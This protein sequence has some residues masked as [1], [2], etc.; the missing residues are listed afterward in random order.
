MIAEVNTRKSTGTSGRGALN[1]AQR[2]TKLAEEI[3]EDAVVAMSQ[4]T[5]GGRLIDEHQFYATR[6][7]Q[8][9]T[10][11]RAARELVVHAGRAAG[12]DGREGLDTDQA[13]LFAAELVHEVRGDVELYPEMFQLE[14]G[15]RDRLDNAEVRS[16]VRAGQDE[17]L[18][19]SIG[20]RVLE[21]RGVN[22]TDLD[23]SMVT[24]LRSTARTFAKAEIAPVAQTL[25][26]KSSLIP[27]ALIE[28]MAAIGFFGPSIDE[29]YGGSAMGYMAMVVL[30]EEL[31]AVSLA[32][33]SLLTR[34]EI[35]VRAL[36]QGGTPEQ[37]QHWLPRIASGE[38]MVGVGITEPDV[39][40]D[41][42]KVECKAEPAVVEGRKGYRITG[43]KSWSTFA[44][45]A[46]ILLELLRTHPDKDLGAQGLSVFIVE[47][48]RFFGT[49]FEPPPQ[50]GGGTIWGKADPTPGYRGMHS[51]S[52]V[53]KDYFVPEE[54]LIGAESG[55][56]KG[57]PL[58]MGG[59][60]AG[61]LQTGGRGTGVAQAGLEKACNYASQRRQFGRTI[62]DYQLTQY[63]LGRMAT[64]VA[65][66]RHLTYAAARTMRPDDRAALLPAMCK[67]LAADV[68]VRVTQEAQLIHGGWGYSDEDPMARYV[69]DALVLPLFEGVKPILEL[70][71][72]ARYLVGGQPEFFELE[73]E[74]EGE[75]GGVAAFIR[76]AGAVIKS[77][78]TSPR[79][80]T[81]IDKQTGKILKQRQG[82]PR[83]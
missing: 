45:R 6:R 17:R 59:L 75:P 83:R 28:K 63:K 61:R 21:T 79:S 23:D 10:K 50:P 60:A 20:A 8:L 49:K 26:S 66:A 55:L 38:V 51:F 80:T 25:H 4:L 35:L 67:L 56:N 41:I 57:F 34:S 46:D 5:T 15:R 27:D 74:A 7:A 14:E 39:G 18:A 31:S 72:I 44:G 78:I 42:A 62:A 13:F 82:E 73:P 77:S 70:K 12:K 24:E 11:A 81:T 40:S 19:R 32:A 9:A 65:A 54:N 71:V 1:S 16:L 2:L 43:Q 33:G 64:H 53:F 30:T 3:V 69:V 68:A 76:T 36:M 58:V 37:R 52:V 29:I 22:D 47:K 48:E